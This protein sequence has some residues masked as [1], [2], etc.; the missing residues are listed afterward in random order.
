MAFKIFLDANVLLDLTLKRE[1]YESARRLVEKIVDGEVEG[2]ISSSIVHI[3]GYWLTK[4]Y[5]AAKAKQLMLAMLVDIKVIDINHEVTILALHSTM[6]DIEDA[7]QYFTALH[8]K[9]DG[10]ISQDK[11]LQKH[12]SATLPVYTVRQVLQLV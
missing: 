10:F 11:Q 8:H 3:V 9:L 4:A 12:A 1:G 2:Y 5:G 7:I 6:S